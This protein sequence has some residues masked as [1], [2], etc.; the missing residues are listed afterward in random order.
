VSGYIFFTTSP[1]R[2]L[3]PSGAWIM[4]ADERVVHLVRLC[5]QVAHAI[6]LQEQVL[7]YLFVHV[8]ATEQWSYVA[9]GAIDVVIA[10]EHGLAWALSTRHELPLN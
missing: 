2:S 7:Q 5:A 9:C 3:K 8:K 6:V 1:W 10:L 4:M